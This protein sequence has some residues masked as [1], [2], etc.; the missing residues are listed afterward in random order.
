MQRET[1]E[2]GTHFCYYSWYLFGFNIIKELND[3]M[4][5]IWCVCRPVFF[6]IGMTKLLRKKISGIMFKKISVS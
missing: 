1:H 6:N 4:C 5:T 3:R 2:E